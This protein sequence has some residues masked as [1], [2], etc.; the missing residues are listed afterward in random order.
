MK[1]NQVSKL[2]KQNIVNYLNV[3]NNQLRQARLDYNM[4][5]ELD[6]INTLIGAKNVLK[7]LGLDSLIPSNVW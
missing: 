3:L 5:L 2:E 6:T 1:V 7:M 4:S